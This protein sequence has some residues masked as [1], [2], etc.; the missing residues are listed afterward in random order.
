MPLPDG[1]E[2]RIVKVSVRPGHAAS[3]EGRRSVRDMLLFRAAARQSRAD[4]ILVPTVYSWFPTG[5]PT[6][7]IVHDTIA[8]SLPSLVFPTKTGKF[9][10]NL[11]VRAALACSAS[12]A[13]VS[14]SARSSMIER[15]KLNPDSI[16]VLTEGFDRDT[17]HSNRDEITSRRVRTQLGVPP[18]GR[19]AI[20][21]GGLSPHKNLKAAIHACA[22]LRKSGIK[23]VLA[24]AG[25][26]AGDVF[27]SE[28]EDLRALVSSLGIVD[29]VRFLGH[30]SDLDLGDL[31]RAADALLFPSLLEGFGLPALE[32]LACG[33][34][35]VTSG[36]GALPE[37]T[38]NLGVEADP[39]DP[40]ALASAFIRATTPENAE[41]LKREGPKRAAL[42]TWEESAKRLLPVLEKFDPLNQTS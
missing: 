17:F 31:V 18:D 40:S 39:N 25:G 4:A 37:V 16:T 14:E 33:T 26:G 13:T 19:L 30:I 8:E 2:P 34:P 3:A 35:V 23:V 10:W 21:V 29:S 42:F 41:L 7:T 5:L 1:L 38:G 22:L 20:T 6:V 12:L 11:K 32:A 36:R 9:L 27:H 24:L 28:A 15:W